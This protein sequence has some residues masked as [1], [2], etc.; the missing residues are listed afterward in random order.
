MEPRNYLYPQRDAPGSRHRA[1][2]P[3]AANWSQPAGWFCFSYADDRWAWSPGVE[4]MHGYPPESVTPSTALVLSHIHPDD[5]QQVVAA[6]RAAPGT[7]RS[8]SSRHRIIDTHSRVHEVMMVGAQFY[9][10][11]GTLLGLQGFYLDLTPAAGRDHT[12]EQRQRIRAATRC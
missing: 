8:F 5:G 3:L 2:R 12:E 11:R 9:D 4:Q 10:R 6:L 7:R 1:D